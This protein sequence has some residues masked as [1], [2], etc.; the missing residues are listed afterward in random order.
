M[1]CPLLRRPASAGARP[2]PG[3]S[4]SGPPPCAVPAGAPPGQALRSGVTWQL[5][6]SADKQDHFKSECPRFQGNPG[7]R[8]SASVSALRLRSE[9]I[10]GLPASPR[11]HRSRSSNPGPPRGTTR[12][13]P[14]RRRAR[15]GWR[16]DSK[17]ASR[18]RSHRPRPGAHAL[19]IAAAEHK[20][21]PTPAR[22]TEHPPDRRYGRTAL[23]S[24]PQGDRRGA[25]DSRDSTTKH[26]GLQGLPC[27]CGFA[28]VAVGWKRQY[29]AYAATHHEWRPR[30]PSGDLVRVTGGSCVGG[31]TRLDRS[32]PRRCP[33]RRGD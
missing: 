10:V 12:C 8:R 27:S 17:D 11:K 33:R 13:L 20:P 18:C 9:V 22:L 24:R 30:A 25:P 5:R 28:V 14:T 23:R 7:S 26:T 32:L 2:C 1:R 15:R 6:T 4:S 3:R 16:R 31:G 29:A 21:G 19:P